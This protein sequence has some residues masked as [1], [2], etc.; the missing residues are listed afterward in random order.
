MSHAAWIILTA[1][2]VGISCSIVGC[3][4]ILR[5]MA[6]LSDAISHTVLL[7]IV[8]A[9]LITHTVEGFPMLIGALV[10]GLLTTLLVQL[11]HNR[12]VQADAAI[13]VVFTALFA[14]GV[15]LISIYARNVHLDAQH[16]LYGEI[17]FVPFDTVNVV[18]LE[19]PIAVLFVGGVL[20][21]NLLMLTLF[22]KE[23]K[24]CAFDP[25]MAT[26]LGISAVAMHYVLMGM[27][28]LTTVSAF[29]SVGV[30]L[31]VGML[32]V[33]GATAYLLTDRLGMMLLISSGIG[34]LSA[35]L[36]YQASTWFNVSISGAMVSI[37][38]ILFTIALFVSPKH[39]ILTRK[40]RLRRGNAWRG[41]KS[42]S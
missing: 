8:G 41:E 39:G 25:A 40:W 28:S 38:G 27:V 2:L 15:L 16:A 12:G 10:V 31:V 29:S 5:R 24:L 11:L 30:I 19:I 4:L 13:G 6:M 34:V 26:A 33:P 9:F 35:L 32:I 20:V 21:F 42:F 3:F 18:G 22:Y 23:L 1:S 7:G 14:L 37:A 36:G 17:T